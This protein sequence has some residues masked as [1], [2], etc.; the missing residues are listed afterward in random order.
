MFESILPS[1]SPIESFVS[2][3]SSTP[4]SPPST[5]K[6]HPLPSPPDPPAFSLPPSYVQ[7]LALLILSQSELFGDATDYPSS[8]FSTNR[9]SAQD[10]PIDVSLF[11]L[12]TSPT[13]RRIS[14]R[15]PEFFG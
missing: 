7:Y 3:Q 15:T 5:P 11:S 4:L 6:L 14:E 1:L 10:E 8:T 13:R 12:E 2:Q 9:M